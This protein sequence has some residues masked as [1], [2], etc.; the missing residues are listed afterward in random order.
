MLLGVKLCVISGI[1]PR[2]FKSIKLISSLELHQ[3]RY[4]HSKLSLRVLD[5]QI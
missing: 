5:I 1:M 4:V 2:K 3:F